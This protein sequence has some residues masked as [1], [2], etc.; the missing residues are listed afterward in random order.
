MGL[1]DRP[2]WREGDGF[3]GDGGP[4]VGRPRFGGFAAGMPKPTP[5]VKWLLIANVGV[6]F[7]QL[8]G[9]VTEALA[10]IPVAWWQIWRYV[11]F[12]FLHGGPIH[13]LFNMIGLYFLGMVLERAWG[14]KRFL[15]FYLACGAFA[16]LCHVVLTV[17]FN[18]L[19]MEIS[20]IGASGG[21]YA[22]VLACAVLFPQIRLVLFLFLVPIRFVAVL[23]IGIAVYNILMGIRA[24]GFAGGISDAAHLGG[25]VAAAFAIW[26]LPRLHRRTQRVVRRHNDGAWER[27]MERQAA[28]QAEVDRILEKIHQTGI[29]SLSRREKKMLREATH[30]QRDE[31]RQTDRL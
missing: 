12:Q 22:I 11:T 26:V 20:L 1:H 9:G 10:V 17:L 16:G 29:T 5:A 15:R 4:G 21:V 14:T 25:A 7:I 2:Y 24:G 19:G 18:P 27:K 31:E 28:E 8:L 30:R 13:L 3:D 23:F 6:F